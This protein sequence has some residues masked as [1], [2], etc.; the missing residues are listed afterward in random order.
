M[1][2]RPTY[3]TSTRRAVSSADD[4]DGHGT[5]RV[6]GTEQVDPVSVD[7]GGMTGD[8]VL[9]VRM[10]TA[11]LRWLPESKMEPQR[12]TSTADDDRMSANRIEHD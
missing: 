8:G 5:R 9:T 7:A 1:P 4:S 6:D 11:T 3:T 2:S 12:A 10:T